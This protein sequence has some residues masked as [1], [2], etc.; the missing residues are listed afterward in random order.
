M[1]EYNHN[2]LTFKFV[3]IHEWKGVIR[4]VYKSE[5]GI[6]YPIE[7]IRIAPEWVENLGFWIHEFGEVALIQVLDK[8]GIDYHTKVH[9]EKQGFKSTYLAHFISPYGS[10]NNCCLEPSIRKNYPRW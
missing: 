4:P 1:F 2:I 9:F 5:S 6:F 7:E 10:N 8:M 3:C